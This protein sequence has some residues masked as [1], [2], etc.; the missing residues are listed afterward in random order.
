MSSVFARHG[1]SRSGPVYELAMAAGE[2][3][4]EEERKSQADILRELI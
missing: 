2:I 4:E 1:D 3:A